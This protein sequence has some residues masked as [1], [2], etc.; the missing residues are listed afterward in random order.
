MKDTCTC[1]E[2]FRTAE[3]DRDHMPCPGTPLEQTRIQLAIVTGALREIAAREWD[4]GRDRSVQIA[5]AA[6]GAV[7]TAEEHDCAKLGCD[8][9]HP[10][11]KVPQYADPAAPSAAAW[12]SDRDDEW[13]A[14]IDKSF[15]TRSGAHEVYAIA[16]KMVGNRHSKGALVALVSWLLLH[17]TVVEVAIR[18]M[19]TTYAQNKHAQDWADYLE[20]AIKGIA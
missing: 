20:E 11:W 4:K 10:G 12:D 19:R 2:K 18:V 7:P 1:G 17:K 16:M 15:P 8:P 14:A 6:L 3:D 5:L 9:H 13:T